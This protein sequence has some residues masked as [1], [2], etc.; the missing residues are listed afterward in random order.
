MNAVRQ[1]D[2]GKASIID[3]KRKVEQSQSEFF[4][5]YTSRIPSFSVSLSLYLSIMCVCEHGKD[6]L[7]VS[8]AL[9]IGYLREKCYILMSF[10]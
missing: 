7:L 8:D 4:I 6:K 5:L 2:N 10:V 9:D 3:W 1:Q